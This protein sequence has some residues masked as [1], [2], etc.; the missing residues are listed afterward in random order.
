[1][2]NMKKKDHIWALDILK[3]T[4]AFLVFL[5]HASSM[6]KCDFYFI[7]DFIYK[8]TSP[9]MTCFFMVSGFLLFYGYEDK[10]LLERDTLVVF[11]KK[12]AIAIL[13]L[14][15]F[16]HFIYSFIYEPDLIVAIKLIPINTFLMQSWFNTLF[17]I[18]HIG[19]TWFVCCIVFCYFLFPL[20]KEIVGAWSQKTNLCLIMVLVFIIVYSEIVR[21][22]FVLDTNY[23]APLFRCLEFTLGVILCAY[24]SKAHEKIYRFR[25]PF[26]LIA[27]ALLLIGMSRGIHVLTVSALT[28]LILSI[29]TVDLDLI[30]RK[31]FIAKVLDYCSRLSYGFFILQLLLW[32]PYFYILSV[33][34]ALQ[35][36]RYKVILATGMLVMMCVVVHEMYEKPVQKYLIRKLKKT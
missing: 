10:R 33:F 27:N 22:W 25:I 9:A 7:E 14:Y 19:G 24:R 13:P 34:P 16:V 23:S 4:C 32:K 8:T 31:P 3:L 2:K 1:M 18:V 35:R 5:R 36:N 17:G 11:Y 12:R 6:G 28:L 30:N 21:Q 29:S 20:I 26:S 15:F